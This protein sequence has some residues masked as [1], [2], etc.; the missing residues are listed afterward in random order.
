MGNTL[1]GLRSS[2]IWV[3]YLTHSIISG[4]TCIG[5]E[6]DGILLWYCEECSIIGNTCSG[7]SQG[8]DALQSGICL[9]WGSSRNN[10]QQNICRRGDGEKQQAYGIDIQEGAMANVVT[11]NDLYQGGKLGGIRIAPYTN[12]VT[13]AGNRT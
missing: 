6:Q 12:T 1:M 13:D 10:V 4:N 7:N 8:T 9:P 5:N 3:D 2:G 11:N